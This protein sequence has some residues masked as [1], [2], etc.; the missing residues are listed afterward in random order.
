MKPIDILKNARELIAEPSRWT[1]G[2]LARDKFGKELPSTS[3]YAT[4]WCALGA[5]EK[6]GD[7]LSF[8]RIAASHALTRQCPKGGAA[9]TNDRLGHDEILQAFDRAISSFESTAIVRQDNDGYRVDLGPFF[10]PLLSCGD[11]SDLARDLN[12]MPLE[13]AKQHLTSIAIKALVNS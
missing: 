4:C 11:A 10:S 8:N 7:G 3:T 1:Q 12:G 5:L 13:K 2:A 6:V 9:E